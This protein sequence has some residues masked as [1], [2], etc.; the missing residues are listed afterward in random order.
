MTGDLAI[1]PEI[2]QL[3]QQYEAR[4]FVD[5][6]HGWGV[7]GEHG[8]G[9]ADYLGVQDKIDIY[10]GTFAKAFASIGGFSASRK[11]VI[12]WIIYNART[13]V[14]AKSLPMVYVQSLRKAL[15][16]VQQGDDR[17]E[18]M[19]SNAKALKGGLG[20]L[21]YFV[22]PGDSPICSV[23]IPVHDETVETVGIRTVSY[24]R[25]RG[26]FVTA[27]TYPVI[28]L[29]LCMYR[30]IPTAEHKPEDVSETIGVFKSMRDELNLNLTIAGEDLAKVGKVFGS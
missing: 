21:G 5:D 18:R 1:L 12:E 29:G 20:E 10:F 3:A 24:L 15:R 11:D 26:I 7:M 30:M 9:T 14:F 4:V 17:R 13:Q 22:G 23:F 6:A 2:T 19:W 27:I 25:E 8:R 16:L 28:P